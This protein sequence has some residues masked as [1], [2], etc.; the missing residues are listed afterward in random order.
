MFLKKKLDRILSTLTSTV[1]DLDLF[2]EQGEEQLGKNAVKVAQ[3]ERKG[4]EI[5]E[6]VTQAKAVSSNIKVLL[7]M[8]QK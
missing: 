5:V 6:G 4:E 3:L 8:E 2:A 1:N 7:N